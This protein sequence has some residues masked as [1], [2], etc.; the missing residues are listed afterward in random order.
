MSLIKY[1]LDVSVSDSS[2]DYW[3]LT[4][5]AQSTVQIVSGPDTAQ[6]ERTTSIYTPP[7]PL[8]PQPNGR[9]FKKT[10]K[11]PATKQQKPSQTSPQC[12]GGRFNATGTKAK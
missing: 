11:K 5:A 4:N 8:H 6:T 9:K 2:I 1:T 3:F 12:P 7:H 10:Q